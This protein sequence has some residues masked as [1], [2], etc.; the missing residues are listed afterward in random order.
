VDAPSLALG[1]LLGVLASLL[2][3]GGLVFVKVRRALRGLPLRAAS[4]S[5]GFRRWAPRVET[6]ADGFISTPPEESE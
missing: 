5:R 6:D 3:L 4:A 1:F 2:T